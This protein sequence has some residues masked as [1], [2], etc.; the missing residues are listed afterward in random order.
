MWRTFFFVLPIT[1]L[2]KSS[3]KFCFCMRTKFPRRPGSGS[4]IPALLYFSCIYLT[5]LRKE[6]TLELR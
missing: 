5:Q 6:G 4:V 2:F 1:F 3:E